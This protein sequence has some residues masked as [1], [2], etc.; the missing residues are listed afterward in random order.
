MILG[1]RESFFYP[2]RLTSIS[3]PPENTSSARKA[4]VHDE[5]RS[6]DR[7]DAPA[8]TAPAGTA[9]PPPPRGGGSYF[10]A[11]IQ[12]ERCVRERK[13]RHSRREYDGPFRQ[14]ERVLG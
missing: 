2:C 1:L 5:E 6:R 10:P 7:S 4:S 13:T 12:Q 8:K 9:P 14:Y 11:R 3:A